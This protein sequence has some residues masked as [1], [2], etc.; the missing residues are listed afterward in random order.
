VKK[1][2][3]NSII[4]QNAKLVAQ[5][6]GNVVNTYVNQASNKQNDKVLK[7]DVVYQNFIS[8]ANV[9]SEATDKEISELQNLFNE[10]LNTKDFER[11]AA[12]RKVISVLKNVKNELYK[13][14]KLVSY[15]LRDVDRNHNKAAKY[16]QTILGKNQK[17]LGNKQKKHFDNLETEINA[18]AKFK[19]AL[20]DIENNFKL[21]SEQ[22]R[23]L[24]SKIK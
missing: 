20:L 5:Q 17:T 1:S 9:I 6:V 7:R 21:K 14:L 15:T 19:K 3:K 4:A 22:L 8:Q 10:Y 16:K 23:S 18:L 11:S 2:L 12:K 24:Y 13:N